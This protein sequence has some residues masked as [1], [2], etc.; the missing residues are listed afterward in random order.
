MGDFKSKLPDMKELTSMGCKLYNGIKN[1]VVDIVHDYQEKRAT[2]ET[3]TEEGSV[4]EMTQSTT[5]ET[6]VTE[7]E[8]TK[9]K[10][11]E[12]DEWKPE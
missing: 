10:K 11:T 6:Q 1:T 2:P 3:K 9:P 7:K 8:V 4:E 12:E 5:E